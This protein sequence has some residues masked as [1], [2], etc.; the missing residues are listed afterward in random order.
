M[1]LALFLL[2]ASLA[3][4]SSFAKDWNVDPA[5]S[6]VG[7]TI[8][9]VLTPIP[10]HFTKFE[11]SKLSFDPAKKS[12]NSVKLVVDVAS[13][14]THVDKRDEHLRSKDFFE[15][16]KYPKM[17]FESTKFE[18][19]E[20]DPKAPVVEGA[21]VPYILEGKL[22]L[23]GEKKP[24]TFNVDYLGSAKG[25]AGLTVAGFTAKT[26][27]KR[28]DFVIKTYLPAVGDEVDVTIHIEAIDAAEAKAAEKAKK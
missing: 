11:S 25:I 16:E 14:T 15:V 26:T 2:A 27:L 19:V 20:M 8:R 6:S 10:G 9:H 17:E 7:F 28:S 4:S 1:K 21:P 13:I 22:K 23:H 5:H 18:K 12:G 3:S 24:V